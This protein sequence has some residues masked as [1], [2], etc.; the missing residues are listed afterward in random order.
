MESDTSLT[1]LAEE[2]LRASPDEMSAALASTRGAPGYPGLV[3]DRTRFAEQGRSRI[4]EMLAAIEGGEGTG[5]I[6]DYAALESPRVAMAF[7]PFGI[8]VV[9]S[10]RTI[11]S[12]VPLKVRFTDGSEL[13]QTT[14]A[15]LLRDTT[16]RLIRFR[17]PR[18]VSR[19]ELERLVGARRIGA[20][21]PAPLDVELPGVTLHLTRA[22]IHARGAI[23]RVVLHRG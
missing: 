17:L 23:I 4:S 20:H 10:A 8:T 21:N 9:D 1:A 11:F 3:E 12:Q 6:L 22:T 18:A 16:Q 5:L 7:I 19:A 2:A 15:P 13:A 14:P